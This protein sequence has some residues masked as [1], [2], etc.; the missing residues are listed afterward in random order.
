MAGYMATD[1]GWNGLCSGWRYLSHEKYKIPALHMREIISPSGKSPAAAWDIERKLDMLREFILLI[2]KHTQVGFGCALDAKHY[3]EVVTMIRTAV[4]T[5]GL[6]TK[7]FDDSPDSG[8]GAVLLTN[9][10]NGGMLLHPFMRRLVEVV[11]DGKPEAVGEVDSAA[12]NHR[13]FLAKERQR[14][15]IPAS[16]DEV[17]KLAD[18]YISNALGD[19]KVEHHGANTIFVF[20]GWK[21]TVASRK[22]DDRTISFITI[23]P[24]RRGFEF[25]KADQALYPF[26]GVVNAPSGSHQ[27]HSLWT[28]F[29]RQ[30]VDHIS[31]L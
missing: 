4:A 10:D 18:H 26:F 9:S 21:S 7:P 13:A 30:L 20:S 6:K 22:N 5:E 17:S 19:L 25:V 14:L 3:R 16:N 23:D 27:A 11:F 2:R 29:F 1:E 15:T 31:H 28:L 24:T 8:T 12:T